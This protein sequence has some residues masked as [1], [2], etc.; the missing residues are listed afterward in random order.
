MLGV[1]V[2]DSRRYTATG[3]WGFEGCK[4]DSTSERAVGANAAT[5]CYRCHTA[6]KGKGSVFSSWRK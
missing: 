1:I 2:K 4:G 5:A 3:G 6:Q